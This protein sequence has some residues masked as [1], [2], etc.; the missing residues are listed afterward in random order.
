MSGS[1]HPRDS[2]CPKGKTIVWPRVGNR[3]KEANLKFCHANG[4]NDREYLEG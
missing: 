2:A 4:A 3:S 1:E